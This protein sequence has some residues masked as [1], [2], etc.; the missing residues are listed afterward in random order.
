MDNA[1]I[2]DLIR[3]GEVSEVIG[4]RVRV[5]FSDRD[6]VVSQPLPVLQGF[7][8]SNKKIE[9][10]SL[11]EK[12]VCIFLPTGL[13][14]GFVIGSFYDESNQPP[15][16]NNKTVYED[17][18]SVEFS[19]GSFIL[20]AV[21]SLIINAPLIKLN[22]AVSAGD[23]SVMQVDGGINATEDVIAGG[24]SVMTHT[25]GGYPVD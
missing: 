16:D 14:D 24:K 8:G 7:T 9:M 25:N 2:R 4:Y 5:K 18:S 17:G 10:P 12:V 3:I 21:A 19:N 6:D 15:A 22:G 20:N 13:E 1:S 23:G 11:N